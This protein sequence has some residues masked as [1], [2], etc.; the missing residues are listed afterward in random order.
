MRNSLIC[1]TSSAGRN[2]RLRLSIPTLLVAILGERDFLRLPPGQ[3]DAD[4][5]QAQLQGLSFGNGMA[6]MRR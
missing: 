2:P 4:L 1:L 6:R 3:R 5:R